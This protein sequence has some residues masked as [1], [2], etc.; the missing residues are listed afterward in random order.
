[1]RFPITALQRGQKVFIR[2]L[3]AE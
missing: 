2:A 3:T 1:M